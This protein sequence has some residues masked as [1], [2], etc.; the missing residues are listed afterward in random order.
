MTANRFIKGI[1]GD[2]DV[3]AT[4]SIAA[5]RCIY[6]VTYGPKLKKNP[7]EL[8]PAM[9]AGCGW[10]IRLTKSEDRKTDDIINRPGRSTYL[11]EK[12]V[13]TSGATPIFTSHDR[14]K[15]LS[16]TRAGRML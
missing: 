12:S 5:S 9:P 2:T 6:A 7:K 14:L 11:K 1:S 13:L 4:L 16:L 8:L 3:A 10:G 15:M